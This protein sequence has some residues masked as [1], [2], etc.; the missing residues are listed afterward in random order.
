MQLNPIDL[1]T[2]RRLIDFSGGNESLAGLGEIQLEGSVALQNMIVDPE[3]GF[4]YLADEVGMG[5]TYIALGVVAMLRYFNPMLRVLYICPSRNVQDKWE[6]EYRSFIRNNIRVNQ[7]RI[8]TRDGKPAAP[9]TSCR[10]VI[11]LLHSASSGY[12]ADYFI[13]KDSFSI[14]LSDDEA[15][16]ERK[17]KELQSL[18]P[19]HKWTGIIKS[20]YD[21]KEQYARA[22]NYILPTFDLVVIDEAHNFKH[23]FNSSDRNKVLSGVLG[24]RDDDSWIPR[25][26]S[27]LL[28]SA[29]PYDRNINQLCNQLKMVGRLDFLPDDINERDKNKVRESLKTFMVRRLN[30]LSVNNEKLTRNMY[31][32]E[33]RKG[34]KAEILL[35]TDEQ[36]LVTALVQKKVGEML[37]K[38]SNSP[39]FQTGLLA[40]F[41]SFAES[42]RSPAVEFDGERA[43]KE[44]TDAKD[45][46]VIGQIS[47]NYIECGLGRTLPH[48]KMDSVVKRLTYSVFQESKKQL[49]FVRRVKSVSEIKGKLD[50]EYNKWLIKH[51]KDVLSSHKEQCQLME[52]IYDIYIDESKYRDDGLVG[53]EIERDDNVEESLPAKNDTFYAWFFR[54]EVLKQ[55]QPVLAN[56]GDYPTPDG[57]RKGLSAKNQVLVNL[58]EPNWARYICKQQGVSLKEIIAKHG[59]EISKM[60]GHYISGRIDDDHLENFQACQLAFIKWVID[61]KKYEYLTPLY[62]HLLQTYLDEP[63]QTVEV[64]KLLSQLELKTIYTELEEKQ[65]AK[66]IVPFQSRAFEEMKKG[67]DVSIT[68]RNFDI[69]KSLMSFILRTAH[70]VV[71]VYLSRLMQGA[72]NLTLQKR[73][74]WIKDYVEILSKQKDSCQFSTYYE[75]EQLAAHLELIVKNNIPE[76]YDLSRDEYPKFLS[77][78]LNPV[79]PIIGASGETTGRSAQAR[80]FRMP[81]YPLVLVSTD[82]FQEGEDLHTFCDSVVHYGISGSPVSIE[83]KTGRVDRVNSLAQRRLINLEQ[84]ALEEDFIQVTFPYVKQS[85]ETLQIRH[86]CKNINKFIEELHDIG[87]PSTS[88]NDIVKLDSAIDSKEDIP[89]QIMDMLHSPYIAKVINENEYQAFNII[90]ENECLRKN[91]IHHVIAILEKVVKQSNPDKLDAY[92]HKDGYEV[93]DYGLSVKLGSAKASGELLISLTRHADTI[94]HQIN[95][96]KKLLEYMNKLSW[97]T[98]HRTFAIKSTDVKNGYQLYFNAEMLIGGENV[99]QISDIERLFERMDLTHNP[100]Q[101]S[102][103]LSNEVMSFVESINEDTPISIDRS[104]ETKIY[105]QNEDDRVTLIFEFGGDQIHRNQKVELYECDGR[106][107]LLSR[108]SKKGFCKKLTVEDIVKYTWMRNRNIDLVE[109]VIDPE[110]SIVGRVVHPLDGI[111]WDEFIYCAYTLAVET[112]NLEYLLNQ[113]DVH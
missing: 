112:D 71:D 65:L 73:E 54:G 96:R 80:K 107:V 67:I 92:F 35:E 101:Y 110:S 86:L 75:L 17:R 105:V 9:F 58:L 60:A 12:Y 82:V 32:R 93:P 98:F 43:D 31:R 36:K 29:T 97:K 7:G 63:I 6:K 18:I 2:A 37:N 21:V 83:Q 94:I 78:S 28:L 109:F 77:Q 62:N 68:L 81:G 20:K 57:I 66:Y 19:A 90:E 5:K 48:P 13:G 41:E 30:T 108:A 8:R 11:D 100:S 74:K 89:D 79:S 47:D 64:N 16:W 53:G 103:S 33:W 87:K 25:V 72:G 69:H 50:E 15:A 61:N 51:I 26:K 91:K 24:L 38:Q 99:T 88:A 84:Q 27:S 14:G 1:K 46:H 102:K 106:C 3:I 76:I 59:N 111:H 40:S 22:L 70:G 42:T 34:E 85:I 52:K 39:S 55:V 104:G 23:D 113:I 95:D 49:V 4:G 10:N 44:Q 45:R 56:N